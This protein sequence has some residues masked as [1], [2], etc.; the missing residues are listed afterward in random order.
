MYIE[1]EAA[2]DLRIGNV[3][4]GNRSSGTI[5]CFPNHEVWKPSP[6]Q[7]EGAYLSSSHLAAIHRAGTFSSSFNPAISHL[8]KQWKA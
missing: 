7:Q 6:S 1:I 3:G 2:F 5:T 4:P 8:T